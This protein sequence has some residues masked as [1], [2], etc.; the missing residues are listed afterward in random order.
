MNLLVR[1]VGAL[2]REEFGAEVSGAPPNLPA[3]SVGNWHLTLNPN[4]E[5]TMIARLTTSLAERRKDDKG[6]TLV[7]LLV[8][9]I[10]IGILAAIAIPLYLNQQ[11]KAHDSATKADLHN[12]VNQIA[13]GLAEHPGAKTV[14]LQD[15]GTGNASYT[16]TALTVPIQRSDSTT[17]AITIDNADI[18]DGLFTL[19][20]NSASSKSFTIDQNGKLQE[21]TS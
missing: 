16:G 15:N 13:A 9:V 4:G 8:V 12:A 10:I 19:T 20:A 1:T 2:K 14:V 6:F 18:T 21:K 3:A 11:A 17:A 7:E 5:I